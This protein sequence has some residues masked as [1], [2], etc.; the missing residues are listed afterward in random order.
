MGA[1]QHAAELGQAARYAAIE[2]WCLADG[3]DLVQS[4][5]KGG[6]LVAGALRR[7]QVTAQ[8]AP[9]HEPR[10]ANTTYTELLV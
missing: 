4:G 8:N 7:N 9:N 6:L 3:S 2:L 10:A 5:F 1:A